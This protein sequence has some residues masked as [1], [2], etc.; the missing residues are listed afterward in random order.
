MEFDIWETTSG[1]QLGKDDTSEKETR[2]RG[3]SSIIGE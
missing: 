3:L 1:E 2:A